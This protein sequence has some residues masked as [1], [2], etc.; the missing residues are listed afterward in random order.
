MFCEHCGK[1][2]MGYTGFCAYCGRIQEPAPPVEPVQQ[3]VSSDPPSNGQQHPGQ[4]TSVYGTEGHGTTVPAPEPKKKRKSKLTLVLVALAAV[5]IVGVLWFF[6]WNA[7]PLA[8]T[9]WVAQDG[10]LV[11]FADDSSGYY[12][13]DGGWERFTYTVDDDQLV[14]YLDDGDELSF[15]F[16]E[17][18]DWLLLAA[19]SESEEIAW[20]N[21]EKA[22][23][24]AY[25][26]KPGYSQKHTGTFEGTEYDFCDDCWEN[27]Q[28]FLD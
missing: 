13:E 21:A 17:E 6:V 12:E 11:T 20:C 26:E 23:F 7:N 3:V 14:L 8:N 18:G 5:I 4:P 10:S 28:K 24:C 27:V 25:C 22:F 2:L 19:A 16:R 1:P 9:R 15:A